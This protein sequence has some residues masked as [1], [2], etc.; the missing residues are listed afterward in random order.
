M[1]ELLLL[2]ES[3]EDRISFREFYEKTYR[4]YLYIAKSILRNMYDA[5]E[6]VHDVYVKMADKYSRYRR[7]STDE[8][9][10]LGVVMVRNACI[11]RIRMRDKHPEVSF[12]SKEPYLGQGDVLEAVVSEETKEELSAAFGNLKQVDKDILTLKYQYDMTYKEISKIL[13]I[14]EKTVDMRLYRA[15]MK[16]K[17]EMEDK[18]E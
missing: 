11:N 6:I 7:Y 16:L 10:G 14:Q 3:E 12:E 9:T 1:L 18:S 2:I 15:K 4:K 13:G 5:E 8:L 17:M